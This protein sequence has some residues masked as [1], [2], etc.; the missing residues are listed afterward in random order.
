MLHR[1]PTDSFRFR[2][3]ISVEDLLKHADAFPPMLIHNY[4]R[5]LNLDGTFTYRTAHEQQGCLEYTQLYRDGRIEAFSGAITGAGGH[6]F[7]AIQ[8]CERTL[9]KGVKTFLA[10]YKTIGVKPP[11]WVFVTIVGVNKA[12]VSNEFPGRPIDRDRL[13][14]PEFQI[15]NFDACVREL[16]RPISELLWNSV[17]IPK[18]TSFDTIAH[19]PGAKGGCPS[20]QSPPVGNRMRLRAPWFTQRERGRLR[21]RHCDSQ[22]SRCSSARHSDRQAP[23][24]V[25]FR[26]ALRIMAD[27]CQESLRGRR[28]LRSSG[29]R[30]GFGARAEIANDG[31]LDA[32]RIEWALPV[33]ADDAIERRPVPP[34]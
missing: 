14:F 31:S 11:I 25:D 20:S 4:D 23:V 2:K 24:A 8:D 30:L 6:Q 27:V 1:L 9:L 5:G 33:Q 18:S 16:I 17:G 28:L 29:R 34:G 7:L 19:M 22:F 32:R 3:H 26:D 15:A 13:I 21:C 10:G 12:R